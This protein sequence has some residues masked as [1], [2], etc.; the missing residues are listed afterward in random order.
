MNYSVAFVPSYEPKLTVHVSYTWQ[1]LSPCAL[2]KIRE[3][4]GIV[5][6]YI[7]FDILKFGWLVTTSFACNFLSLKPAVK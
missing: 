7:L 4:I 6:D 5:V 2:Q 1:V 3:E